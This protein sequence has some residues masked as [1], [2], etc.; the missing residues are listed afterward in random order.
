MVVSIKIMN[1]STGRRRI[2]NEA[3]PAYGLW[4]L[5]LINSAI[6]IFFAFSIIKPK[7]KFGWF[8]QKNFSAL[9]VALFA[10]RHAFPLTICL[11]FGRL[12]IWSTMLTLQMLP[13][14][15]TICLRLARQQEIQVRKEFGEACQDPTSLP[16]IKG[17]GGSLREPVNS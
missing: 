15:V 10:E 2:M 8:S 13:P 11:F 7:T 9:S 6:F 1:A 17:R 16:G 14:L 12:Q 3:L 5:A 4:P